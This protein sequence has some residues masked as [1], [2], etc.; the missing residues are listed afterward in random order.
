MFVRGRGLEYTL[1]FT[2]NI[3]AV[4]GSRELVGDYLDSQTK[5]VAYDSNVLFPHDSF[6]FWSHKIHM[7]GTVLVG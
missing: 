7:S 5:E 6:L 3:T 2:V 4:V 1:L